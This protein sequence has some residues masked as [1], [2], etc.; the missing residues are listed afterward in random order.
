M[1]GKEERAHGGTKTRADII[2]FSLQPPCGP[3]WVFV[4]GAVKIKAASLVPK[5]ICVA[6][7]V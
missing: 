7:V 5:K 1:G 6:T 2:M 4:Y 3:L